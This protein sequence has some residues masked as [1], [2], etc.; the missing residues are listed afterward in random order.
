MIPVEC[1]SGGRSRWPISCAMTTPNRS[2]T[3]RLF[4][5]ATYA[6]GSTTV[7][8]PDRERREYA[9]R[10]EKHQQ[11]EGETV[12]RTPLAVDGFHGLSPHD[13]TGAAISVVMKL[14]RDRVMASRVGWSYR[15]AWG[16]IRRAESVLAVSLVATRPGKGPNRGAVITDAARTIVAARS[17]TER[18]FAREGR[19]EHALATSDREPRH[20][21]QSVSTT[22]GQCRGLGWTAVIETERRNRL[23]LKR[24]EPEV[25]RHHHVGNRP[26]SEEQALP[27]VRIPASQPAQPAARKANCS[28][29][30]EVSL[31][32]PLSLVRDAQRCHKSCGTNRSPR[33]R[34]LLR[35][36]LSTFGGH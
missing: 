9:E 26:C 29:N 17:M 24:L 7:Q 15:H 8:R 30:L 18:L 3:S 27:R 11:K 13:S 33:D 6:T 35:V 34:S 12:V 28:S 1:E 10:H 4:L 5:F 16:Y 23:C 19:R 25:A 36:R 14:S 2:P 32:I 22:G 21:L 31:R 20:R